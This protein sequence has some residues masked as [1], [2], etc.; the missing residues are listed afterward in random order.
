MQLR[1]IVYAGI[2][3]GATGISYF[4]WDSNISRSGRVF[5]IA[6][7]PYTNI[8]EKISAKPIQALMAHVLWNTAARINREIHELTPVIYSPTVGPEFPC[9]VTIEGKVI[10]ESPIRALLKSHPEGGYVLL[11]VNLDNAVLKAVF[12]F[13]KP[14]SNVQVLFDN[15]PPEDLEKKQMI[16]TREY[17]PYD[18]QIFRLRFVE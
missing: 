13:E 5:G 12:K 9:H 18:V 8:P 11:T 7:N 15:S 3:H 16:V 2:I 6:P 1:A 4:T 17:E 10:T 14:L